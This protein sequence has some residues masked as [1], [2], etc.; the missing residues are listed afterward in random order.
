MK[1]F[2]RS[3][4]RP[5]L[6]QA[7]AP[8]ITSELYVTTTYLFSFLKYSQFVAFRQLVC[9]CR[10]MKESRLF[11][12]FICCLMIPSLEV[13]ASTISLQGEIQKYEKTALSS[14][15]LGD[16]NTV[17]HSTL[18]VLFRSTE[19]YRGSLRVLVPEQKEIIISLYSDGTFIISS[20]VLDYIDSCIFEEAASSMRRIRAIDKE[21]ELVLAQF[22]VAEVSALALGQNL[23]KPRFSQQ[24]LEADRFAPIVLSL[25]G[26]DPIMYTHWLEKLATLYEYDSKNDFFRHWLQTKPSPAVRLESISNSLSNIKNIS[27]E[28]SLVL[29]SIKTGTALKDASEI[30]TNLGE[31]YPEALY[32]DRL[33]A[34]VNHMR[35]I[36]SVPETTLMI[37]PLLPFA[38]EIDP[39]RSRFIHLLAD[40]PQKHPGRYYLENQD[41]IPG[42]S[43]LFMKA[44]ESYKRSLSYM[45]DPVFASGQAQ[46]LIWSGNAAVRTSAIRI[47]EESA[48]AENDSESFLARANFASL[49]YLT[50]TDYIRSQ[51]LLENLI[52][53]TTMVNKTIPANAELT[54]F[55]SSGIPGDSR[56]MLLNLLLIVRSLTDTPKAEKLLPTFKTLTEMKK[57]NLKFRNVSLGDNQDIL[58]ETW[59]RPAEIV[60]N[61]VTET[62]F[63][64][65]LKA[66]VL[67]TKQKSNSEPSISLIRMEAG[68]PVSPGNDLRTGDP[69]EDFIK[70]FGNHVYKS[71]DRYVFF[72][73]ENRIS[74]WNL[75]GTIRSMTIG[76]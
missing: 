64:P 7:V 37:K 6:P 69:I 4:P 71:G 8:S 47:A 66:S 39:S 13:K 22:I 26:Y 24:I 31:I 3:T 50:G 65:S 17:I 15:A 28:F 46:L 43:L 18:F 41:S 9:Y 40:A 73:Q 27:S 45:N 44:S 48:V 36:E 42:N 32:L 51:H 20:G 70:V 33:I 34:L 16:W 19:I 63:Y 55:V 21:R 60:Y 67:L 10:Y 29:A 76:L 11:L 23:D 57:G 38:D 68:S 72:V 62:W 53:E 25:A 61:Y 74:V 52:S 14:E 5:V 58:T 59:G 54:Q 1:K 2:A 35:W 56:D 49:L 30:C 12:I 75:Y